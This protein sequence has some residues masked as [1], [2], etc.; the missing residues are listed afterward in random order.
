MIADATRVD[1]FGALK[2][3]DNARAHHASQA[4]T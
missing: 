3:L 4:Q 1:T 2:P